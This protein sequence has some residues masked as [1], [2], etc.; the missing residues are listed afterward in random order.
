MRKNIALFILILL[1]LTLQSC[2]TKPVDSEPPDPTPGPPSAAE[3]SL[4]ESANRFGLTLFK[5]INAYEEPDTNI[6]ISPLSVSFA[7]GMTYNG[8]AGETREAM[9]ATLEL[10]GL[11]P[12]EINQSYRN[13]IDLLTQLDPHVKFKIANSIWTRLGFPIAPEFAELSRN[14]FDAEV[15]ELDFTRPWAADTINHWVDV[16]TN[17]KITKVISPP[18]PDYIVMYLINAIYFNG[19]WTLPFDTSCTMEWPFFRA[20]GSIVNCALMQTDTVLSYFYNDLF[21]AVDLPYGDEKFS[22]AIFLPRASH[23][24]DEIVEQ[25]N[26]DNWASWLSSFSENELELGLPRFKFEYDIKLNDIL[27]AMGMEI[28]FDEL[29]ADFSN[30]VTDMSL[31]PGNLYIDFVQHKAFVQVNEM[32]TE[33]AAVTVVGV[34][35][36]SIDPELKRMIVDRPF[37]FVIHERETGSILFMGKVANPVWN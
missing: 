18:I 29:M 2:T 37:L 22:M 9:A 7:L 11:S 3:K 12:E 26:D 14:Y 36:T 24:V 1:A 30:M 28:A 35:V 5:E 4:I 10:S 8:A 33:A 21:Q 6:F 31:L 20:D 27:M 23:T 19:E 17:G 15:R 34:G 16:N 13:V 32:G 25:L